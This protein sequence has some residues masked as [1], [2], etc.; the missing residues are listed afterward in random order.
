MSLKINTDYFFYIS[1]NRS[2]ITK[3]VCVCARAYV[4]ARVFVCVIKPT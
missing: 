4:R 1:I 2:I 3:S